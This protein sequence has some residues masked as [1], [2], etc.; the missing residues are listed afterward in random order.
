MSC[1]ASNGA[2]CNSVLCAACE[3]RASMAPTAAGLSTLLPASPRRLCQG[4]IPSCPRCC[5]R[6]AT[7]CLTR[8]GCGG[9]T[10]ELALLLLLLLLPL[11]PSPL[12]CRGSTLP[13][14]RGWRPGCSLQGRGAGCPARPTW[15]CAPGWI[16]WGP[17]AGTAF[18]QHILQQRSAQAAVSSWQSAC[19]PVVPTGCDSQKQLASCCQ[20]AQHARPVP[21]TGGTVVVML[22]TCQPGPANN[23]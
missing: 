6:T 12:T 19:H 5:C 1:P 14:T 20:H 18:P 9:T 3:A 10:T 7:G 16:F 8:P 4:D 22:S 17:K 2:R 13:S 15:T 23:I 11:L 21:P